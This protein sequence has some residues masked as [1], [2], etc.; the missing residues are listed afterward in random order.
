MGKRFRNRKH[1]HG[2]RNRQATATFGGAKQ[3]TQRISSHQQVAA[4]NSIDKV[5]ANGR[6]IVLLDNDDFY[7]LTLDMVLFNLKQERF[8]KIHRLEDYEQFRQDLAAGKYQ[9]GIY[10]IDE[11]FA[12]NFQI[13]P[14]KML[15]EIKAADPKA[16]LICYSVSDETADQIV[17]REQYDQV[18]LKSGLAN[19][20]SIIKTLSDT[21][22]VE[23]IMDNSDPEY[24][25]QQ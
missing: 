2:S 16:R 17:N 18:V 25:Y 10:I 14:A 8:V 1:R 20:A 7:G 6:P 4:N 3:L 23:F 5:P 21:L 15:A 9:E 22:G 19:E 24:E 13:E 11:Y 12:E